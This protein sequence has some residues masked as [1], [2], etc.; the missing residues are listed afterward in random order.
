MASQCLNSLGLFLDIVG[1]ILL[2]LYGLPANVDNTGTIFLV[3][4][5]PDSMKRETENK[6]KRYRFW[7][8]VGL[9]FLIVGFS[10][11]IISN[12]YKWLVSFFCTNLFRG[13]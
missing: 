4:P 10:L 3:G 2:F 12:H 11:Q 1:V 5:M 13:V 9:I 7:S 6:W 8:R